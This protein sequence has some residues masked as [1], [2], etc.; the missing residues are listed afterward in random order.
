MNNL[1]RRT[2][3]IIAAYLLVCVAISGCST[4]PLNKGKHTGGETPGHATAKQ[5]NQQA[6]Q[7]YRKA[8]T[9]L[10]NAAFKDASRTYDKVISQYPFTPYATQSQLE[11]IYAQ[12]RSLEPDEAAASAD[13]FLREHPRYPNIAYVYY[14]KGLIDQ[15]R[16]KSLFDFLPI[17]TAGYDPNA[18]KKAF[19]D[20]ALLLQRFPHTRYTWDARQRMVYLRNRIAEHDLLIVRFYMRR[21]AWLAAAKRAENIITRYPGAPATATALLDLKRCDGKLGLKDQEKQVD[22]LI[23]TNARTIRAAGHANVKSEVKSSS[24]GE[25]KSSRQA[26]S[27]GTQRGITQPA[28]PGFIS[29]LYGPFLGSGTSGPKN[30]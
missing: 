12:Y 28:H 8:H 13:R 7:L 15:S 2:A 6:S 5:I 18:K 4:T 22:I 20:F 1:V 17:P 29:D 26:V 9:M 23:G 16:D 30:H 11:E 27:T 14:L 24:S 19:Q 3:G 21:G 10:V 25:T